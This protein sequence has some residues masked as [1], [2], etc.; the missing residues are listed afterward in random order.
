MSMSPLKIITWII[1]P[2]LNFFIWFKIA[3]ISSDN[4]SYSN[5]AKKAAFTVQSQKVNNKNIGGTK[6]Y[7]Y[8]VDHNF[9]AKFWCR[10]CYF[11]Y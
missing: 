5:C 11:Y 3:H 8:F 6:Y 1:L 2:I 10:V 7:S 9:E 4:L